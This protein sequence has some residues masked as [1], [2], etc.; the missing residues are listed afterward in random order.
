[1]IHVIINLYLYLYK[2]VIKIQFLLAEKWKFYHFGTIG[3]SELTIFFVLPQYI[4]SNKVNLELNGLIKKR[5]NYLTY[6]L[7]V[8]YLN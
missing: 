3:V 2:N 8:I 6:I 1:M 4:K 5:M 7:K